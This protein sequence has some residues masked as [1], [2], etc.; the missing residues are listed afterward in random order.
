MIQIAET[1]D[2]IKTRNRGIVVVISK[3]MQ[4]GYLMIQLRCME[5][6]NKEN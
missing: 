4:L 3:M 1:N 5:K 2:T 6:L